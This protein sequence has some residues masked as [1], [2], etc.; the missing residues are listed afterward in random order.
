MANSSNVNKTRFDRFLLNLSARDIWNLRLALF[1]FVVYVLAV[2]TVQIFPNPPSRWPF[3]IWA[4]LLAYFSVLVAG[5]IVRVLSRAHDRA[6][7]FGAWQNLS[8]VVLLG[9]LKKYSV[10]ERY[11]GRHTKESGLT[12]GSKAER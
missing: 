8:L 6:A 5:L 12:T 7:R 9:V 3:L 2:V 10:R 11:P 1:A 4:E